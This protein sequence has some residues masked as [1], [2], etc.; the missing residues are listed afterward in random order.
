MYPTQQVPPPPAPAQRSTFVPGTS[1]GRFGII[2]V[3][4][5]YWDGWTG[6]N[7]MEALGKQHAQE[8]AAAAATIPPGQTRAFNVYIT[9]NSGPRTLVP[10]GTAVMSTPNPNGFH[11][12][13]TITLTS[14]QHRPQ[15]SYRRGLPIRYKQNPPKDPNDIIGPSAYG[16]KNFVDVG[17][18]LPYSIVFQNAPEAKAWAARIQIIQH[19]DTNL[20]WSTFRLGGIHLGSLDIAIPSGL[21]SVD[22]TLDER[23]TLGVYVHV[24]AGIDPQTGVATWTITALDPTTMQEP[25][26]PLLGL[27]PPDI[28][29]PQ[30]DGFVSYTISPKA[31]LITGTTINAEASI[32]FDINP[33]IATSKIFNTIDAAGP[34]STIAALPGY[35]RASF[36]VSWSGQDDAG[37]AGIAGYDVYVSDN[38]G[39]YTSLLTN[40]LATSTVFPG[41]DGHVY[42]F[43]V[44][45]RD[46]VGHKQPAI[47]LAIA[48]RVD[49]VAPTS[50]VLALPAATS[51]STFDVSWGGQDSTGGSGLAYYDIYVSDNGAPFT[52][53]KAATT[54]TVGTFT[55]VYGHSYGFYSV[56]TDKVGNVQAAAGS[57]QASLYV[58]PAPVLARLTTALRNPVS[59]QTMAF[60]V[61]VAAMDP[62]LGIPTGTVTLWDGKLRL[63]RA[64]LRNG[65][66]IISAALVGRGKHLL[67]ADY[68]GD[69]GFLPGR[70]GAISQTV[71]VVA[72][73]PMPTRRGKSIIAI[74]G[75]KGNDLIQIEPAGGRQ[76][77]IE[78]MNRAT[79]KY[80]Y[81]STYIVTNV[82]QCQVYGAGGKD[83]L[84]V[85]PGVQVPVK[86]M[87]A[88][89]PAR[90]AHLLTVDRGALDAA[91]AEWRWQADL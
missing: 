86:M 51:V 53:W 67:R 52:V 58:A 68:G 63:G 45:S 87:P 9:G 89:K 91:L 13:Y 71:W 48:T 55:G 40:I 74:G 75:T 73:Q 76:V 69:V 30:G 19:L 64:T 15:L 41:S 22:E 90:V 33:A 81:Q 77:R 44:Q 37:G 28:T 56:A 60:T 21:S 46:N 29:P 35:S 12:I 1:S 59:G 85:M 34:S 83:L 3:A 27:L 10:V 26:D 31:S 7:Q 79:H 4:K 50:A 47:S 17:A 72:N 16:S 82:A 24:Q 11:Y 25:A 84:K 49:G 5:F 88:P 14:T 20:D 2:Q 42:S 66:A 8:E 54:D 70:T 6:I 65:K 62:A 23:G 78:L 57:S 32:V 18:V 39:A 36:L 61:V 80:Y 43:V 38:G